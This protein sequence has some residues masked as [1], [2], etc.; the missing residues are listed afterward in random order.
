MSNEY[1]IIAYFNRK[2]QL[3]RVVSGVLDH[4]FAGVVVFLAAVLR[5]L[6]LAAVA[7]G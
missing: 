4:F 7:A 6:V 5:E 2:P 3:G 1:R